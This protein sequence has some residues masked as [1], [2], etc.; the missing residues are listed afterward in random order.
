MPTPIQGLFAKIPDTYE[1]VN[2]VLT[3]GM[4]IRWRKRMVRLARSAA[5]GRWADICTGTGE[6]AM[7]LSSAAPSG[8]RV[9]AFYFTVPM[10]AF[11]ARK[12]GADAIRFC[13]ADT[14]H[15]PVPDASFSVLTI[16][17][18][19]RNLN[20]NREHLIQAFAECRRILR[21]GGILLTVETSRPGSS[22]IRWIFNQ[23]VRL[24]VKPVGSRLSGSTPA[25]AYLASTIPRFYG[26][27]ELG[28]VFREA[29]FSAVTWQTMMF[30]AAAIHRAVK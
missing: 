26:A 1:L 28:K 15:L 29:G 8:T 13:A 2:H 5:P 23:Y 9:F 22:L 19:L 30:G 18:A 11:A 4:D 3:M 7:L 24:L 6:T 21:P 16:S 27:E 14:C 12:P 25:Y 20:T 10:L 17:F